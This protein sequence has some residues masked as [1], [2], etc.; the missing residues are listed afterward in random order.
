[1]EPLKVLGKIGVF[2]FARCPKCKSFIIN[3]KKDT[4]VCSNCRR[5]YK[6]EYPEE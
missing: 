5:K 4:V 1:M 6:I 2:Y 3:L